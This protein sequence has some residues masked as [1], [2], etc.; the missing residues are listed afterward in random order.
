MFKLCYYFT[1]L[2]SSFA[3]FVF[4]PFSIHGRTQPTISTTKLKVKT[5]KGN[6]LVQLN[7][8]HL[9]ERPSTVQYYSFLW[10]KTNNTSFNNIASPTEKN[11][12]YN[13]TSWYTTAN[14]EHSHPLM[15]QD[16]PLTPKKLIFIEIQQDM[17][18]FFRI[19]LKLRKYLCCIS[20]TIAE[21]YC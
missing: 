13:S 6:I 21:K 3:E 10:R 8:C 12:L 18:L 15:L 4:S 20:L 9:S 14:K 19:L 17:M 2:S 1:N 5:L 7:R 16:K 11:A